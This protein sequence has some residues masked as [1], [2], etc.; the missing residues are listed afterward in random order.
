MTEKSKA[1]PLLIESENT[2][3]KTVAKDIQAQQKQRPTDLT[4]GI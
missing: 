4:L 2:R 1:F 3:F